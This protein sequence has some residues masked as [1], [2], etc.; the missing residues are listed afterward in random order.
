MKT[1]VTHPKK[2]FHKRLILSFTRSKEVSISLFF[3]LVFIWLGTGVIFSPQ[4][5]ANEVQAPYGIKSTTPNTHYFLLKSNTNLQIT[6]DTKLTLNGNLTLHENIKGNG[7]LILS[8]L[9]SI[10][11]NANNHKINAL[12]VQENT[13]VKL[14]GHLQIMRQ[15]RILDKAEITLGDFDLIL[16][17]HLEQKD[18]SNS[19]IIKTSIGQL[20]NPQNED[21]FLAQLPISN[22]IQ[23]AM[24]IPLTNSLISLQRISIPCSTFFLSR[25]IYQWFLEKET[26]PPKV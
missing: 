22:P 16:S 21:D 1:K 8:S 6:N 23:S 5:Y 12:I 4:A 17:S 19:Q 7:S 11:L 18:F 26:P 20:I 14:K 25:K 10:S 15:L 2:Q 3:S 9:G 13:K 24:G